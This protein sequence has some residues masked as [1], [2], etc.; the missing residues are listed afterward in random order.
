MRKNCTNQYK[1]LKI[2]TFSP[3]GGGTRFYGQNDFMGVSDV[4]QLI[5]SWSIPAK[6]PAPWEVAGVFLL[7]VV[8]WQHPKRL[9]RLDARITSDF[10]P[11]PLASSNHIG[12]GQKGTP[13]RGAGQKMS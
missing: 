11:V 5:N 10:K 13:G 4:Q 12:E 2:D 1:I 8:L 3:G 9:W 6:S 7:A